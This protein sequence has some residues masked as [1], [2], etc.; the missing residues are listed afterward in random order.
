MSVTIGIGDP[1]RLLREKWETPQA[2]AEELYAMFTAK[3]SPVFNAPLT[4]RAP[5]GKPAI[6]IER[7]QE[8]DTFVEG[9]RA[10]IAKNAVSTSTATPGR[11]QAP[12]PQETIRQVQQPFTEPESFRNTSTAQRA[13][14]SQ[15][16]PQPTAP[17]IEAVGTPITFGGDGPVEFTRPPVIVSPQTGRREEVVSAAKA[18]QATAPN[19]LIPPPTGVIVSGEGNQYLVA[20]Y[21]GGPNAPTSGSVNVIFPQLASD[22][23]L[24][25]GTIVWDV[26][27]YGRDYFGCVPVWM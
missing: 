19:E 11:R 7:V 23:I 12:R 6:R 8:G 22:E 1:V 25:P 3:S 9:D 4:I 17:L 21:P 27:K 10:A 24:D 5:E 14:T 16:S 15:L 18:Y 2:L 20:L 13:S 26:R